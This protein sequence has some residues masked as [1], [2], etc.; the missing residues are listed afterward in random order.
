M[1]N[2]LTEK[3]GKKLYIDITLYKLE[4]YSSN[5]EKNDIWEHEC[6]YFVKQYK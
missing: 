1:D 2:N 3:S 5:F 4:W 6:F